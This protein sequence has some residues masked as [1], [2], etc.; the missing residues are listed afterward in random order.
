MK[1]GTATL[2]LHG[3][4]APAWLF[5]RMRLMAR[6]ITLAIASEYGPQ[7]MLRRLSD[8]AW[9]QAFG[10]VLGFDWH[11]SGV[12][13]T[14]CGALKDGLRGLEH[15]SGLIVAGGKGGVSRK[16]P[17]EIEAA[18]TSG[19]LLIEPQGLVYASKMAAKVDSSGLQDGYQIYHHSFFATRAGD[20]AVVQQGMNDQ[21]RKARRYHWLSDTVTD[22]V[23]EPHKAI[24]SQA[25]GTAVLNMVAKESVPAQ[26]VVTHLSHEPPDRILGRLHRLKQ[27]TMPARHAVELQDIHPDSLAKIF[28]STYERQPESFEAL[29]GMPGVGPK[30]VRA[31]TLIAELVYDT[32]ASRND[33]ALFSYAH[34]GKDGYP[35]PVDRET[36]DRNIEILRKAVGQAKLGQT[37]RLDALR[38]LAKSEAP[39]GRPLHGPGVA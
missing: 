20:W 6:E 33:P 34:G 21:N 27:L 36:Y 14:V 7:Q 15:E 28:L 11:S 17:G 3:G 10:A 32:P 18:A 2:P 5:S 37:E 22:Y 26:E 9:F 39:T 4:K 24:A 25:P 23:V 30:T 19:A 1:T 29:L 12:T 38:R 31:L 16:T 8:P 13:T 35:Y